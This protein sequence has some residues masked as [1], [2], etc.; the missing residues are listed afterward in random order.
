MMAGLR[1][2]RTNCCRGP[3]TFVGKVQRPDELS[4]L[5]YEAEQWILGCLGQRRM[6]TKEMMAMSRIVGMFL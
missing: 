1:G 4:L 2:S 3:D 6:R 5:A